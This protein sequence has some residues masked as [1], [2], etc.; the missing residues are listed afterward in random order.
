MLDA[1]VQ[2]SYCSPHSLTHARSYCETWYYEVYIT[3]SSRKYRKQLWTHQHRQVALWCLHR[4]HAELIYF[5]LADMIHERNVFQ[6]NSWPA[7]SIVGSPVNGL[8]KSA[9]SSVI[10]VNLLN[11]TN[12]KPPLSYQSSISSKV[13]KILNYT[14]RQQIMIPSLELMRSS[15]FLEHFYAGSK[16]QVIRIVKN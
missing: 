2:P 14:C 13:K 4:S 16:V 3:V 6:S 10:F 7:V 15:N 5:L 11:E 9:P 1:S 8:A 12:W